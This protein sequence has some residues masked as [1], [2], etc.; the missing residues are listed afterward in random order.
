MGD[1]IAA[2]F[3][4]IV[5]ALFYVQSLELPPPPPALPDTLGAAF[6]PQVLTVILA[7]LVVCLAARAITRIR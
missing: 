6:F 2:V 4:A 5:A 3:L 1:L 7:M